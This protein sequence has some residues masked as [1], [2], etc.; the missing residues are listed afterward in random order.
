ME[1]KVKKLYEDSIVPTFANE[2]AAGADLYAHLDAP[3]TLQPLERAMIGTGVAVEIPEGYWGAV[4]IRS[5]IA[6]K[7]G[8]MLANGVGVVDSDYRGQIYACVINMSNT[9][10]TFESGDRIAQLV[11]RKQ[12]KVSLTPIEELSDTVRAEGG[13]GSTG[14]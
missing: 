8:I 12:E 13:F 7:H 5:G 1:V 2:Y 9:T 14:V 11:I 4:H 6:A 10:Y 3:V